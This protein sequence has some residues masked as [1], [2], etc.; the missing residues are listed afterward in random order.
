MSKR[1]PHSNEHLLHLL[2]FNVVGRHLGASSTVATSSARSF[3][4]PWAVPGALVQG[5]GAAGAA[6]A[7]RDQC[8]SCRLASKH[9]GRGVSSAIPFPLSL[10]SI[11]C[12]FPSFFIPRSYSLLPPN[13]TS[14]SSV[15][16]TRSHA[17]HTSREAPAE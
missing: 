14:P 5:R 17:K 4:T 8:S 6:G 3:Y 1:F 9:N 7:A 12:P 16:E 2:W 10:S 13:S 15:P 11:L